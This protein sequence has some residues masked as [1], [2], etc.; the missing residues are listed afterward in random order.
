MLKAI[1][2]IIPALCGTALMFGAQ[3][4]PSDAEANLCKWP[5]GIWPSMRADCLHGIDPLWIYAV[6]AALIIGGLIW[7]G[8]PLAKRLFRHASARIQ[9]TTLRLSSSPSPKSDK[10]FEIIVSSGGLFEVLAPSG[11]NMA[12]VIRVKIENNTDR[13]LP[14]GSLSVLSLD[15]PLRGNADWLLTSS[16]VIKDHSHTFV[17]VAGYT[18]GTWEH[19]PGTTIALIAPAQTGPFAES[20]PWLPLQAHKFRLRFWTPEGDSDEVFCR[21]FVDSN[22]IVRLE[23]WGNSATTKA[24]VGEHLASIQTV[25]AEVHSISRYTEKDI[26]Q[27]RD[28]LADAF[29]LMDKTILPIYIAAE[30]LSN[31]NWI[32]E[33]QLR[34]TQPSIDRVSILRDNIQNTVWPEVNKFI[35]DHQFWREQVRI[36]LAIDD[37]VAVR[38]GLTPAID[39]LL[40][41]LTALP[42]DP[43]LKMIYLLTDRF[44]ALKEQPGL[45]GR[46]ANLSK[47]RIIEMAENLRAKGLTGFERKGS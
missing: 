20:R 28:V 6:A 18:E 46:W 33:I 14:N 3:V 8:L 40:G 39:T 37:E 32:N 19:P 29:A 45:F 25:A 36:A 9:P 2:K 30:S 5:R 26:Q 38:G 12:R 35:A 31:Q 47:D 23:E 10:S 44:S 24:V 42:P 1:S 13:F 4:G 27:R 15:P 43:E 22:N 21:L 16:I 17:D 34:G 7:A 41:G 11:V